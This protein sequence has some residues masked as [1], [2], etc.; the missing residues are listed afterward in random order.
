MQIPHQRKNFE[1]CLVKYVLF[2]SLT[3]LSIQG[4]WSWE[5][6]C[7]RY[8]DFPSDIK[9]SQFRA[10][11]TKGN[12]GICLTYFFIVFFVVLNHHKHLEYLE[13]KF[14]SVI[15]FFHRYCLRHIISLATTCNSDLN[16]FVWPVR[17]EP[18]RKTKLLNKWAFRSSLVLWSETPAEIKSV[19]FS[20]KKRVCYILN[21]G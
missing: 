8:L 18:F 9:L 4:M 16:V 1:P 13:R 11:A 12:R 21:L 14:A 20:W 15:F 10:I 3:L 7:F 17:F 5:S 19:G 2:C 6:L